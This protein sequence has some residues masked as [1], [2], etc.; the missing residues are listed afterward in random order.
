MPPA[1]NIRILDPDEYIQ[2]RNCLP[3]SSHAM[4]ETAT[5]RFH[6]EGLFSEVIFGQVG[7][8]DRLVRR[9]FMDLKTRIM[10]PHLYK[11][12]VTLKSFYKDILA[13]KCYAYY[14]AEMKDMV[15]T[16]PDDPNG[17]TG[18]SF[19]IS[20]LP[21][22]VFPETSSAKR[23]DKIELLKKYNDVLFMT[24]FIVLPAGVRDV[25]EQNGRTSS[26]D[27][28]KLYLGLL[29]LTQAMPD[30]DTE[31]PI[32]D[33]VRYQIQ[34]KVQQI[35]EYIADLFDGKGGFGQ[36]KYAARSIVYGSRNVITAHPISRV[37]SP[38]KGNMFRSN[39][40]MV[41]LFQGMKSASPLVIYRLRT[42]FFE[43]IFSAQSLTV[44]LIN[45]TTLKL[46]YVEMESSEI[47]KFTTSDGINEFINGFR[48]MELHLQP[49]T[50]MAKIN[51]KQVPYYLGLVYDGGDF[52]YNFR[53]KDD[54]IA[55]FGNHERYDIS[56]VENLGILDGQNKE[57]IVILGSTA[58][59]VY[60]MHHHNQ[61][62]DIL[63]S[64]EMMQSIRS[65]PDFTKQDNGVYRKK[66][67]SMDVYNDLILKE[68]GES[69]QD[70]KK[71][72]TVHIGQYYLDSPEHLLEVYRKSNR[73]KDREKIRFLET[74]VPDLTKIRPITYAEMAY[75]ATYA[76]LNGKYGTVTRHPVLNLEG[77]QVF[78]IHL[79]STLPSRI[80][81]V[82]TLGTEGPISMGEFPEYPVLSATVKTSMSVHPSTLDRYDGDHD[83]DVL[84]LNIAMSEEANAEI[85]K[86]MEE[87]MSMVNAN[88]VLVYG[89]SDGKSILRYSV[90]ATSYHP[91]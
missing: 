80:V 75:M 43:Q 61:D 19:F 88:G 87:P 83:G 54:L 52:I 12:L 56:Q 28:N 16:T 90:F 2:R 3:V 60:G 57:N 35:Y 66:D 64:E 45:P 62:L 48:N 37:E 32:F 42:L 30:Q 15:K 84:G 21:K 77:I 26:E 5:A 29:S 76:A 20:C 59:R 17:D 68:S 36:S 23:H 7:S 85:A 38:D 41:P 18:Y 4:F 51:G 79:A 31:D 6:P 50:A 70:Y 81:K 78:K 33:G 34:N 14:D 67:G 39:E 65:N 44:P 69:F 8:T 74:I 55:Y 11:Q 58:L 22:I 53:N 73:P 24:R 27:I 1:F 10:S 9:G 89:T 71:K 86:Y 13:G 40:V 82:M 91:L 49:A 47:K 63:V 46:E 72:Y 25:K